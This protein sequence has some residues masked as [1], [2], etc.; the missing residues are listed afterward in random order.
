MA[1][2]KTQRNN[3]SVT[4]FLAALDD[5]RQRA[6]AKKLSRMMREATGCRA[7]MW[8]TSIV[9]F[10]S[11]H[12][13]YA[14]GREGDWPIVG[15]SPRK[16]N[17]SIYIMSGFS[18]NEKLMARLGKH[19]TGKSCLYLKRL[20]DVDEQVLRQLIDKSVHYMRSKYKTGK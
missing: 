12:Y 7:K 17:L 10:G 14:S 18:G 16:Q 6:D 1:Q 13:V 3:S 8:G 15:Y 19:K 9:G 4:A 11:Y 20:D 5:P 2:Q